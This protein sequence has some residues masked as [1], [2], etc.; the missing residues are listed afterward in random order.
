MEE[1][2]TTIQV[3]AAVIADYRARLVQTETAANKEIAMLRD[4]ISKL[5]PKPGGES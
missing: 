3:Q 4:Q 1:L 2:I 5:T